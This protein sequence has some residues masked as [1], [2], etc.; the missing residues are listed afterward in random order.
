MCERAKEKIMTSKSG[1]LFLAAAALVIATQLQ[2]CA[3]AVGAAAG[4]AAG[5]TLKDKGYEVRSPV[6]KDGQ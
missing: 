6:H 4:A 2:G 3:F 5:Y 1:K